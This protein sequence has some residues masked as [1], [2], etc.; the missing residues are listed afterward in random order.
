VPTYADP[1]CINKSEFLNVMH[2]GTVE[3][4]CDAIV[5]AVH[6]IADY[7]WLVDQ[8]SCLV[9]HPDKQVKGVSATCVGH[10]ARLHNSACRKTLLSILEPLLSD[11]EIF[12]RVEDAIDDVNTYL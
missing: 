4:K 11:E 6:H 7:K 12:G 3:S 9:H 2:S 10:L 1:T 5:R 8:F